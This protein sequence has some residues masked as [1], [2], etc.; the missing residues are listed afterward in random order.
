MDLRFRTFCVALGR[1][2][3]ALRTERGMTQEDMMDHGFSVRHYQRIEAG[4]S[5]NLLTVWNLA[6]AFGVSPRSILPEAISPT[7]AV[8]RPPGKQTQ[9]ARGN[10]R[11]MAARARQTP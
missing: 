8:R 4:L 5:I 1:H 6:R 10:D 9:E 7:R 3:R 2:V 11:R